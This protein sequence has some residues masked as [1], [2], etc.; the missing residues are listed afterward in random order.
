MSH[1]I[2]WDAVAIASSALATCPLMYLSMPSFPI[3]RKTSWHV[4]PRYLP[5]MSVFLSIPN[6]LS[7][8]SAEC[9]PKRGQFIGDYRSAAAIRAGG[10]SLQASL[11]DSRNGDYLWVHVDRVEADDIRNRRQ[12]PLD[13]SS[14]HPPH[15][16]PSAVWSPQIVVSAV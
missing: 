7:P 5:S 2:G 9:I 10:S 4:K 14:S 6:S 3:F 1:G 13:L 15:T 11:S 8:C 12:T 16:P